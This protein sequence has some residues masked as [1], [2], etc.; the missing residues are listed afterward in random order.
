MR[1]I[2]KIT[3]GVS[4]FASGLYLATLP[5]FA[6]ELIN[7]NLCPTVGGVKAP[8]CGSETVTA[9]QVIQF[10]INILLFIGFIAALGFLLYGGI[11]W[12]ISGGDKEA[13]AKAKG[14]VTSAL[15]GLVIVLA[16]WVLLNVVVNLLTG[17][18]LSNLS[19]P[20]LR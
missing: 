20:T 18:N 16:S 2:I 1:K 8:G 10:G 11:R 7:T 9:G 17:A 13:T 19:V 4:T 12:I 5:V 6:A 3:T 15:I 14:T